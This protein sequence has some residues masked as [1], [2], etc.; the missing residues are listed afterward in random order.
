MII[1]QFGFSF[2]KVTCQNLRWLLFLLF[3]RPIIILVCIWPFLMSFANWSK[4]FIRIFN[5]NKNRVIHF[6]LND[7]I[8]LGSIIVI[9]SLFFD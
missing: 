6:R 3:Q 8:T 5:F 1:M 7:N 4:W 9:Y 2:G